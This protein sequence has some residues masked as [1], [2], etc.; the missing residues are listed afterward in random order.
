MIQTIS[1]I[2]ILTSQEII[3]MAHLIFLSSA[4]RFSS[5]ISPVSERTSFGFSPLDFFRAEMN[6]SSASSTTA[7][8]DFST[9][10][11]DSGSSRLATF[12]CKIQLNLYH[13]IIYLRLRFYKIV[14]F[15]GCH[16]FAQV[17]YNLD[18]DS[19]QILQHRI[20]E[21]FKLL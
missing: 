12:F 5:M 11:V 8:F 14:Q 3:Q 9:S 6:R 4:I 13:R 10:G 21:K 16:F 18:S 1:E 17:Y 7:E 20:Y 15:I 19:T 2:R